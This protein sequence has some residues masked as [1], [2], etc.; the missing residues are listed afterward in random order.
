MERSPSKSHISNCN[1]MSL[2]SDPNSVF[3]MPGET[4]YYMF[5]ISHQ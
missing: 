4:I 3:W 1:P 5:I 2:P